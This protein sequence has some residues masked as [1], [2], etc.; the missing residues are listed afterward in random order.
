LISRKLKK[1]KKIWFD[2]LIGIG[3]R[4]WFVT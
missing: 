3:F 4:M 2:E 1:R